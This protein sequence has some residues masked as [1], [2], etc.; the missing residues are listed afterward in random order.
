MADFWKLTCL[1]DIMKNFITSLSITD[2]M[3]IKD[4][5]DTINIMDITSTMDIMDSFWTSRA[6]LIVIDL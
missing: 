5:M 4:I 6:S 2:I 3:G 1:A